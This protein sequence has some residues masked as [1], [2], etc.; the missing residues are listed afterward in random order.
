MCRLVVLGAV[1]EE[2]EAV[3]LAGE[4]A[5]KIGPNFLTLVLNLVSI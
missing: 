1:V 3:F 5:G 2:V 4:V